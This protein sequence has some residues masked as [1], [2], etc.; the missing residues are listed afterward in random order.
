MF[1]KRLDGLEAALAAAEAEKEQLKDSMQA[2][3]DRKLD[4]EKERLQAAIEEASRLKS[5][6][7][8]Q[9]KQAQ[10]RW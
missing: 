1:F 2:E 4:Q 9:K 3:R 6:L 10:V 8:K 5:A 7:N